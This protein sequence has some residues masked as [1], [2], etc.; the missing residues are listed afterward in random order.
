MGRPP[1]F[2]EAGSGSPLA[3]CQSGVAVVISRH[4]FGPRTP[5]PRHIHSC[6]H[7]RTFS[8]FTH[9]KNTVKSNPKNLKKDYTHTHTNTHTHTHTHTYIHTYIYTHNA[10]RQQTNLPC[11]SAPDAAR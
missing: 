8:P 11:I 4:T 3:W 2:S 10:N 9:T 7:L 6:T 1:A 5:Q